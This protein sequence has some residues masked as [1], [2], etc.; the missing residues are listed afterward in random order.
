MICLIG[1]GIGL[2]VAIIGG[3]LW[4]WEWTGV[5]SYIGPVLKPNQPYRPEKTLWDWLQLLI[6][7]IVLLLL[8]VGFAQWQQ[9]RD[10][11]IQQQRYQAEQ[12][13]AI[14][15]QRES[16]LQEYINKISE[17]LLDKQLR[18]CAKEAEAQKIA[19]VRVLTVLP[20]LD[21]NRKR[22]VVQFLYM[23]PVGMV[24]L[25]TLV[26]IMLKDYPTR[27]L[28]GF[29]LLVGQAFLYNAIFFTYGLVLARFYRVPDEAIGLYLIP[30]AVGNCF[31]PLLLGRFFDTLGR[32][33]MISFTYILPGILLVLT[34]WL[35]MR[36]SLTAATQTLCWSVIF[37]FASAGASSAYLT[38]SEIFP[39]E[40]RAQAI[41]LFYAVGTGASAVAPLLFGLLIQSGEA[42]N[43]FFGYLLGAV[44]MAAAGGV[45]MV[46][47][48]D[49][50]RQS[51]EKV[52]R[53]LSVSEFCDEGHG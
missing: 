42:I 28:L 6:A 26:R 7:P 27:S 40:V 48:V 31:G 44:V 10:H 29:S 14:D 49:A 11:T 52:A 1:V 15:N 50:E 17:L 39:L 53:P 35:F 16:A 47:G 46:F 36:G 33:K 8:G 45:E 38:V 23:R 5:S 37:F 3:Y 21:A 20:R 4:G 2:I 30:F 24:S 12:E 13:L 18:S 9:K 19:R 22:S 34:G 41:A 25:K 32:R 43:V 51:L